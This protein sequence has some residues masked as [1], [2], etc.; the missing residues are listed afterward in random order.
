MSSTI[1]EVIEGRQVKNEPVLYEIAELFHSIQGEGVYT[2]TPM[3]FI[4][5]TGCS[6]G[7]RTCHSC[8]TDFSSV[9]PWK[10]GTWDLYELLGKIECKHVCLTGGEPL[11]IRKGD[12]ALFKALNLAGHTLHVETSG[13]IICNARDHFHWVTVCPKPGFKLEM[14]EQAHE[15]KVIVGGL[16]IGTGWP[17]L[18]DAIHW[19][20]RWPDKPVFLQPRN[21]KHEVNRYNLAHAMELVMRYPQ[22][23][24]SVQLHKLLEVR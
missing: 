13:T 15:I 10:G 24:L 1:N 6:V 21:D 2:G 17:Q 23:R 18:E 20:N 12:T 4:R 3:T 19:A 16:G 8:D 11:D 7:K 22:L 5:F 14:L 9:V